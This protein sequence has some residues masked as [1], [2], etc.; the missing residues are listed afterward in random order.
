MLTNSQVRERALDALA[1][2]EANQGLVKFTVDKLRSLHALFDNQVDA[3]GVTQDVLRETQDELERQK[4]KRRALKA[5]LGQMERLYVELSLH[6]EV[7]RCRCRCPREEDMLDS[8]DVK[9]LLE[10]FGVD[11]AVGHLTTAIHE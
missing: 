9:N 11:D 3:L 6:M 10:G 7:T 2:Q 5:R 4:Q 1:N 8:I